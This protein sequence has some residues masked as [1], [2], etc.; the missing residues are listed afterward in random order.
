M[1][2]SFRVLLTAVCITA[3]SIAT[4]VF[5]S[6]GKVDSESRQEEDSLARFIAE[7][8]KGYQ[9]RPCGL[10]MNRNGILGEDADRLVGDG[11]TV[12]PDGDGVDEELHYVDSELGNDE[13]GSGSPDKPFRTIQ[14]A[15]D[16]ADG[17]ED[18]AEDVITIAGNTMVGPFDRSRAAI[19]IS[20]ARRAAHRQN[21]FVIKSNRVSN[22]GEGCNIAANYAPTDFVADENAYDPDARFRWDNTKHWE[23][24]S[25]IDWQAATGQDANS[26]TGTRAVDAASAI[27]T[28]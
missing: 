18:G 11:T 25:F 7:R 5:A 4:F 22:A 28:P 19:T 8:G 14:K 10:D 17:P 9:A 21:G 24:I 23:S 12:D 6:E 13:T 16:T 26:K 15:L 3:C 27:P 2:I 20:A 1:T